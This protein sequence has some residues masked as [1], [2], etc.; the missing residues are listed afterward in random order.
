[1]KKTISWS[2][3]LNP[4]TMPLHYAKFSLKNFTLIKSPF[5]LKKGAIR[6]ISK[7]FPANIYLF[8]V[9]GGNTRKSCETCFSLTMFIVNHW[10]VSSVFIV[11]FKH[12]PYPGLVFPLVTLNRWIFTGFVDS[13]L[14]T[15]VLKLKVYYRKLYTISNENGKFHS[16][17]K[18]ISWNTTVLLVFAVFS[19]WRRATTGRS[20]HCGRTH[21]SKIPRGVSKPSRLWVEAESPRRTHSRIL[22]Y[23]FQFIQLFYM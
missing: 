11:K 19:L 22:I 2:K 20:K 10:R 15:R 21:F 1:M 16:L 23:R 12:I 14:C 5:S 17:C 6:H 7:D 9:I 3:C 8:K 4:K 18:T 13:S